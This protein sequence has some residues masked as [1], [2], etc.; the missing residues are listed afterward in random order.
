MG[1]RKHDVFSG[2]G[3]I[4]RVRIGSRSTYL[5]GR[6]GVAELGSEPWRQC[7]VRGRECGCA[8]RGVAS[9]RGTGL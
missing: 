7:R 9:A 8:G 3:V 4:G 6:S 1:F 2:R 5:A